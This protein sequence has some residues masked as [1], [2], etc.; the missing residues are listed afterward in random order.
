MKK[1]FSLLAV[2]LVLVLFSAGCT[3]KEVPRTIKEYP[4][5]SADVITQTNVFFDPAIS[6]DGKGSVRIEA[7]GNMVINLYEASGL[8]IDNARLVYRAKVKTKGVEGRVF[9]EMRC[10]FQGKGEYFSRGLD[11]Y[12]TGTNDWTTQETP[13]FLKKGQ[14]PELVKLN[15]IITG[16][17]TVWIDGIKLIR[18]PLR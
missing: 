11:T 12:L 5:N 10:V 1:A 18:G 9:L 13:F 14:Q 6:V 3:R 2:L 15:L 4:L 8:D 16:K 17:G 7:P